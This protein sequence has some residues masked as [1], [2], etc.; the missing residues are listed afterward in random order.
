MKKTT[1]SVLLA[2]LAALSLAA[3]P[4]PPEC[5][6][7]KGAKVE[8]GVV[9]NGV[10]KNAYCLV[11]FAPKEKT[12]FSPDLTLDFEYRLTSDDP[13]AVVIAQL[14]LGGKRTYS[15][16]KA[17]GEWQTAKLPL[18]GVHYESAFGGKRPASGEPIDG[19]KIYGRAPAPT[20]MTLELKNIAFTET[21]LVFVDHF[22]ADVAFGRKVVTCPHGG[23]PALGTD[24]GRTP[25]DKAVS[26]VTPA[27]FIW[28]V[29]P[30]AAKYTLEF[31][32]DREFTR[33]TVRKDG[34]VYNA[35]CHDQVMAPGE[36][37]WRVRFT[38]KDG[39]QSPWSA[40][41]QVVVARDA[42]PFPMPSREAL[43][44][45]IPA[46]HP[47]IIHRPEQIAELKKRVKTDLKAEY[48]RLIALCDKVLAMPTETGEP[49]FHRP[50]RTPEGAAEWRKAYGQA[51]RESERMTELAF[52]WLMTGKPEYL[53]AARKFLAD[54]NSW[55]PAGSTSLKHNDEC[56][57]P[58]LRGLARTYT[59]LHDVLT[60]EERAATI[61]TMRARGHEAMPR[62]GVNLLTRPFNSHSN[63]LFYF[64]AEAGLAFHGEI[65]EAD[66]W[67]YLPMLYFYACYPAWGDLD[68]GWHEGSHYFNGYMDSFLT[69]SDTMKNVLDLPPFA[70]P[71]FANAGYYY[72]YTEP[73][74][75]TGYGW[76][77]LCEYFRPRKAA[78][79][80]RVMAA[81]AGNPYWAWYAERASGD[82]PVP[83]AAYLILSRAATP[84]VAPKAPTD[85]PASRLFRG[86]GQAVLSNTIVSAADSVQVLF[87]CGAELGGASHGYES[88]N[89]FIVN[90]YGDRLLVRA[91]T[92]DS[93]G[94]NFHRNYMHETK[95][96]NN[97]LIDGKGMCKQILEPQ[98]KLLAFSTT[99]EL[100]VVKGEAGKWYMEPV[101][102]TYTREIRFRKPSAI[103]VIDRLETTKP[104]R[105]DW[106]LHSK[107][108]F[109]I[110][111]QHDIVTEYTHAA[112]TVDF[113]YP[114]KLAV[115]QTDRFDPPITNP[116]LRERYIEHH[117]TATPEA[118]SD[119][120]CF[121]T[122]IRPYKKG[123]KVPAKGSITQTAKGFTVTVPMEDGKV[124]ETQIER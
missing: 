92:R 71:F 46:G 72:L 117:L 73:P 17:N 48:E 28:P 47:R 61:K 109:R 70:K 9:R 91:G 8:N 106:L 35:Y 59:F 63:R 6:T 76:G 122:L 107:A 23:H 1:I 96:Q 52:G 85:L 74:E 44:K 112:S 25:A 101:V 81:Q 64:L 83:L 37:Y 124:W 58:I 116:R 29:Q 90:A 19:L 49:G 55:D 98:G 22:P 87:K 41:R 114:E 103:L 79:I 26:R 99:P 62:L 60:P 45:R 36:W 11:E 82:E 80:M 93:Y 88:P 18:S 34:L 7:T 2:A 31:A 94:S 97:I 115:T 39:R 86:T 100:D 43:L 42:V 104:V 51:Q 105:F 38:T 50:V 14:V 40:I 21:P 68:G 57:M 65:E 119:K 13:K 5:V 108:P 84:K 69:W 33:G 54:I 95:S 110:A 113:L 20:K 121:I 118:K 67:F 4:V 27:A 123:G 12:P 32:R 78:A 102:K 77:D 16:L 15:P 66:D 24:L 10:N 3:A 53:A 89:T 30:G 75:S 120:A 111:D 56:G